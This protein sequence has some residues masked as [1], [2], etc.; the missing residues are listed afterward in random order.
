MSLHR[1]CCL[2]ALCL[3]VTY[4]LKFNFIPHDGTRYPGKKTK[5]AWHL[6]VTCYNYILSRIYC[7]CFIQ[8]LLLEV[9][10]V[11][12]EATTAYFRT[13]QPLNIIQPQKS[14]RMSHHQEKHR[15]VTD[16]MRWVIKRNV[17]SSSLL[18]H[19][20]FDRL[21]RLSTFPALYGEE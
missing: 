17:S 7:V 19:I 16:K 14:F 15:K 11:L 21:M 18:F 20:H 3:S 6:A 13:C 9:L 5:Q 4:L 12:L 1:N 8:S 10:H 2:S